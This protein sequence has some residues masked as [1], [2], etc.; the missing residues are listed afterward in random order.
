LRALAAAGQANWDVYC[1]TSVGAINAAMLAQHRDGAAGVAVLDR[2]WETIDTAAIYRHWFFGYVQ[3]LVGGKSLTNSQ[4]LADL[5]HK[6]FDIKS[7]ITSGK[8][9]R[10]VA[11]SLET[12]QS[13]VWTE[14]SAHIEK[15]I[16]ASA[17]FPL[18]FAPVTIDGETWVDGGVRHA[19][20]LGEAFR[21]GVDG[22]DVILTFKRGQ[23]T[24]KPAPAGMVDQALRVLE[25]LIDEVQQSDLAL[26]QTHNDLAS[27]GIGLVKGKR[28]VPIRVY[29]P[30]GP[31]PG[32]P[33]SFEPSE[34]AEMGQLGFDVAEKELKR[35]RL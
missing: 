16:V 5:V 13:R 6:Y 26:A 29:E 34:I 17:A 8:K 2:I 18:M 21:A 24:N 35:W 19:T 15:A 32:S 1:G 33:L 7:L 22:I 25:I 20:P 27:R 4:P 3:G 23:A 30:D 28:F 9:L 31:L 11:A 12:Y 14:Q 10:V